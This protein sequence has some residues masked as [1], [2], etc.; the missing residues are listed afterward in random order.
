MRKMDSEYPE[1]GLAWHKGYGTPQHRAALAQ[2]GICSIHR[3]S[4]NIEA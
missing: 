4:L 2:W 1:Y 3:K